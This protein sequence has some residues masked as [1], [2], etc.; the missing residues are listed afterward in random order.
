MA[1]SRSEELAFI[2][3][4]QKVKSRVGIRSGNGFCHLDDMPYSSTEKI[5]AVTG[6]R[7][8]RPE[9]SRHARTL[10]DGQEVVH[11]QPN[12]RMCALA[13]P[14]EV[15]RPHRSSTSRAWKIMVP[16]RRIY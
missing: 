1:K 5:Q 9:G 4:I 15:A 6:V 14:V 3:S 2:R 11:G 7:E 10:A 16:G 8:A 13:A 12:H